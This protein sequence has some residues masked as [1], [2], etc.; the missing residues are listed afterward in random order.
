MA[1]DGPAIPPTAAPEA[2]GRLR[3]REG[4]K[5]EGK[6]PSSDIRVFMENSPVMNG[7]STRVS[8]KGSLD[9]GT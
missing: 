1:C 4:S 7:V 3:R 2:S 9:R 5:H 8:A 6:G